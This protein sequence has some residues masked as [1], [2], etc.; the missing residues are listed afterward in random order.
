MNINISEVLTQK[1]KNH[2]LQPRIRTDFEAPSP[3][4]SESKLG[5]ILGIDSEMPNKVRCEEGV[6]TW[7]ELLCLNEFNCA[8][9][10]I[11]WDLIDCTTVDHSHIYRGVANKWTIGSKEEG[12]E[13]VKGY[14]IYIKK[15]DYLSSVNQTE[16]TEN[17]I[18]DIHA[19]FAQEVSDYTSWH[20]NEIYDVE[21][22]AKG[23]TEL[24]NDHRM[25]VFEGN[26]YNHDD[27]IEKILS[28][29]TDS[30]VADINSQKNALVSLNIVSETSE[31]LNEN[32]PAELLDSIARAFNFRM[33]LGEISMADDASAMTVQAWLCSIPPLLD[34]KPNNQKIN[35]LR[36]VFTDGSINLDLIDAP[37]NAEHAYTK[38]S[39]EMIADFMKCI[40]HYTGGFRL[41]QINQHIDSK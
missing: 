34:I 18:S 22:K 36:E 23:D 32:S 40:L 14:I 37:S 31:R 41:K 27:A 3:R 15:A 35:L 16:L 38:W 2:G 28:Q 33:V 12:W 29:M 8:V 39:E 25:F 4:E 1:I 26:V 6:D 21:L 13:D 11:I 10:D 17:M 19:H 20:N 9:D 5:H 30:V 7:V 24:L